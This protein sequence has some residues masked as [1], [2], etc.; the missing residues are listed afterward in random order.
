MG[1]RPD[2]IIVGGGL[3]GGLAALAV[4][5]AHPDLDVRLVERD[6]SLGGNHVWSFFDSD[7]GEE[8]LALVRPM[9][10]QSWE[11]NSVR[12]PK[13]RRVFD[14]RYNS[15]TSDRFDE[16]LRKKLGDRIMHADVC[17]IGPTHIK[18]SDGTKMQ[19][20]ATLDARG[21]NCRPEALR[22]GF[23]KFVGQMLEVE[24]GHGLSHPIIMDATVDQAD[25]Y[26]FVYCLPFDENRVFVEDTY[27][28]LEPQLDRRM[29]AQRIGAY[30]A[31]QGWANHRVLHEED[32]VL[33][34]V[35]DGEWEKL[36][37]KDSP[38]AR[39]GVRGGFFH[40]LT[41]Y[42]LPHA[43]SFATWLAAEM[44]MD[45]EA[46]AKATRKR[47]TDHW[48]DTGFERMLTRMLFNAADPPQRWRVMQRFYSLPAGLIERFYAGK[49]TFRDKFRTL[50]GV[51]PVRISRAIKAIME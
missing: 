43:A 51:P 17:E 11:C 19:A 49:S 24:G 23:Q 2:L 12:F 9:V 6:G 28:Q 45:G 27:Y 21:I 16:E 48:K 26:R 8:E 50:A 13:Y 7:L 47:A 41:S 34:V 38:V 18:L 31:E 36:W 37:P 35:M 4:V 20:G 14:Q 10:V 1:E 15:I 40:Y 33:P 30:A 42:S 44:P 5:R 39:A 32:G 46:L 3:A 22:C 25:G 29:L